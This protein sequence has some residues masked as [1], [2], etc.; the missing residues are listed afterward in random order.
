MGNEMIKPNF[1]RM[2]RTWQ[3]LPLRICQAMAAV[4]VCLLALVP[5]VL[6]AHSVGQVQTTKYYAPETVQLLISRAGSGSPGFQVGDTISYIVQFSPVANGAT[7][8]AA[9]YITDYIPPGMQVVGAAIVQQSGSGGF[10]N[11]AP[12]LPGTTDRGWGGGA[13]TFAAPFAT[14]AYANIFGGTN[15]CSANA[16]TNNCNGSIAQVYADTG[17][18][19]S[20]DSRT[21]VFP[22]LP[23]RIAQGTNGYVI[24]PT[25]ANQLNGIIG[26][27]TATTHNLWD[28]QQTNAFGTTALPGATPNANAS[29]GI[30]SSGGRHAAPFGAGSAVAGPQTGYPLDATGGIGPWQRISYPGSRIGDL[31]NG[32]AFDTDSTYDNPAINDAQTVLGNPTSLGWNVSPVNPLPANTNAVRWAVGVLVV[33]QI[34][35]VKI[36]LKINSLV[37]EFCRVSP[38]RRS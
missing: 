11:I 36:S 32:P 27:T 24:N 3:K 35:Y 1:S 38:L 17:I 13:N 22:A 29:Q 37:L 15:Q 2:W 5:A 14:A 33:P 12:D 8:G 18:F 20:T 9:G 4:G 7:V 10:S 16:L 21:T 26:Q 25:A 30:I 23:T 31:N 6:Y 34:R 19:F 28:A